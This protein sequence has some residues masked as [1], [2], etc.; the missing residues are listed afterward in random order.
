MP[1]CGKCKVHH[2]T[3]DDVKRCYG[4]LPAVQAVRYEEHKEEFTSWLDQVGTW[5]PEPTPEPAPVALKAALIHVPAVGTYTVAFPDGTWRTLRISP[6]RNQPD[7][8]VVELLTGPDNSLDFAGVGH[9]DGKGLHI[10]RRAVPTVDED[11]KYVQAIN[12]LLLADEEARSDM[13]ELYALKSERCCLCG[14]KLTVPASIHRGM[15][16]DCAA[17]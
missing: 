12:F 13:G 9:V 6:W 11:P 8:M 5:E 10:W 1:I 4:V 16:P 3:V 2:D 7:K 17:K 14:R 15:G